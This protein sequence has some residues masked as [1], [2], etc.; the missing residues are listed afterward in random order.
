[1]T[2]E[3][4]IIRQIENQLNRKLDRLDEIDSEALEMGYVIDQAGHISG[5]NVW[6]V[7]LADLS[8]LQSLTELRVLFLRGN[9][10]N[11]Q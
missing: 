10:Q 1:M 5:L 9:Q 6:N 11:T 4:D 8:P 7:K 3:I 2:A